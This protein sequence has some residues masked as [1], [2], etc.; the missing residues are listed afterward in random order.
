MTRYRGTSSFD[1]FSTP[2][3]P[4]RPFNWVQWTGVALIVVGVALDLAFLAGEAGWLPKWR[5]VPSVAFTPLIFGVL[6]INSRRGPT[7]DP[8]PELAAQRRKWLTITIAI[9][10]VIL[11][12][13]TIIDIW[14]VSR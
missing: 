10:T 7:A 11:G 4:A 9:V 5:A 1:P 14:M 6:L 3:R 12:A 2:S 13:A 8:A